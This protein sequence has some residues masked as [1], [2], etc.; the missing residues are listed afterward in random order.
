MDKIRTSSY[1][2]YLDEIG[3]RDVLNDSNALFSS[4]L[5]RVSG[6]LGREASRI[7]GQENLNS[8]DI[9]GASQADRRRTRQRSRSKSLLHVITS[10]FKSSYPFTSYLSVIDK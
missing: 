10:H 6:D 2:V 7:G 8:N 4:P 1:Q 3:G 5:S 9:I